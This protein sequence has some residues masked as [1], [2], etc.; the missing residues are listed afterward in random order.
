MFLLF[1]V[2]PMGSHSSKSIQSVCQCF[3]IVVLLVGLSRPLPHAKLSG[4]NLK[5]GTSRVKFRPSSRMVEI[6]PLRGFKA[7]DKKSH[8]LL[9]P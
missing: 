8:G 5:I 6:E 7:T 3:R 4:T 9:N 1:A 2:K